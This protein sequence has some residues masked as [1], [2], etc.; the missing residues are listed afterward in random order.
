[1]SSQSGDGGDQPISD[2]AGQ[3]AVPP[4]GEA[5]VPPT[6]AVGEAAVPPAGA[7]GEAAVP[8]A[9]EL[10]AEL[11]Q[12]EA[13]RDAAVAALH[14][15]QGRRDRRRRKVRRGLVGFL[16]VVFSVL[17]P[18][19]FVVTWAHYVALSTDGFESTLGPIGS[20]PRVTAA[21]S[22]AVTNQIFVALNPQQV[23][24]DALPPK[25]AFLA[26]PITNGAKGFVQS[27]VTKTLQSP[28]F[29]ALW[30]QALRFAH[31]QLLG[32]LE[33]HSNTVKTT[34]GQ[35]VLDLVPL[36][37][38][39]LQ[40]L[41]GFVSG[42]VGKPVTLPPISSNE[43]P[44]TA[45]QRIATALNRPVPDTCGQ[46]VLFPAD[47]LTQAR[48][49][50]RLFNRSTV[51]LLV[52]TP[53]VGGAALWL[54]R[55]RRRTLLQMCV[56]GVLGLVLIRRVS[57]YLESTLV[58]TGA[59]QNK[60]A[61]QAILT[62]VFHDFFGVS[63]WLLLGLLVI[64]V[65]ALVTG[66]YAWARSVRRVLRHWAQEGRNL[67]AAALGRAGDDSTVAWVRAHLDLLR[68]AGVGV[69]V[70]LLLLLSVSFVGLLIIALLLAAY[71]V[72]L[73]RIGQQGP[74]GPGGSGLADPSSEEAVEEQTPVSS[75]P[76]PAPAR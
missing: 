32:V 69:A 18:L 34:N 9:T 29:A 28:Q 64:F 26:G 37:N 58:N 15:K 7:A 74:P 38:D 3:A 57:A 33:G 65:V 54:S 1:M 44:A 11:A 67:G 40:N 41:G 23:V 50:V 59:P 51:L 20:D 63:R 48:R 19:T 4:A 46:I 45:C 61:R 35:V 25:A 2:P 5:A 30:T 27:A 53:V 72:W 76:G 71:E 14:D 62:Q 56:G 73:H 43:L 42:V 6:G 17:L 22:V 68:V 70:V 49:G 24:S 10:T 75:G 31:S 36:V 8:D 21:V 52:L 12:V 13:E 60:A 16:V 66:P 47:K 55:R 39:S